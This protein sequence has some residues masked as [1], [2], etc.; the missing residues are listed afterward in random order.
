MLFFDFNS[1]NMAS[2]D[3]ETFQEKH[4]CFVFFYDFFYDIRK[5]T[6]DGVRRV[7]GCEFRAQNSQREGRKLPRQGR[8]H[9]FPWEVGI[10]VGFFTETTGTIRN[11]ETRRNPSYI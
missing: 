5:C 2:R 7:S 8:D 11:P 10:S 1:E 9:L 6:Y 3:E 4:L